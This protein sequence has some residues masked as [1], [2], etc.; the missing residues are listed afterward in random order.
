M[1]SC[2]WQIWPQH[3]HFSRGRTTAPVICEAR[4][5]ADEFGCRTNVRC[6]VS[7]GQMNA[8]VHGLAGA[9]SPLAAEKHKSN[10]PCDSAWFIPLSSGFVAS[11]SC[12]SEW[13]FCKTVCFSRSR[14]A[15][16]WV[17][18][19]G[20]FDRS[21]YIFPEDVQQHR[22]FVKRALWQMNLV[23]APT[24]AASS[25]SISW[26]PCFPAG[27]R[28]WMWLLT[29][30]DS[31]IQLVSYLLFGWSMQR[32][33]INFPKFIISSLFLSTFSPAQ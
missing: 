5:V 13:I 8:A 29:S 21:I 24:C 9:F 15:P 20:K 25:R 12:P 28:M 4:F 19:A 10:F 17:H 26:S 32:L 1:S 14:R 22:W 33:I 6:L 23:A 3:L 16:K 27:S 11:S 31:D 18:V 30:A 7:L 2:C